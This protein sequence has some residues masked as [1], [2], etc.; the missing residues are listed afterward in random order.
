MLR[1]EFKLTILT[2]YLKQDH[3]LLII[4]E[5]LKIFAVY[6]LHRYLLHKLSDLVYIIL[7]M[8][9]CVG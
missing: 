9:R 4:P 8:T 5:S 1:F 3:A 2:S 6:L 7:Q